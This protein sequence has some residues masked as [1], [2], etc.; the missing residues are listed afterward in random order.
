[1]QFSI[2]SIM[3]CTLLIALLLVA[4]GG[5]SAFLMQVVFLYVPTVLVIGIIYESGERRTFH[6]G[7]GVAFLSYQYFQ[8][9]GKVPS[10]LITIALFVAMIFFSGGLAVW[11]RRRII[12]GKVVPPPRSHQS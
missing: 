4:P 10:N 8:P 6:I 12:H 9:M 5:I 11:S 1:M 2:K 3:L 7:M